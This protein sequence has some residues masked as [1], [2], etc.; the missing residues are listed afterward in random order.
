MTPTKAK[1][2]VSSQRSSSTPTPPHTRIPE[3]KVPVI[4]QPMSAPLG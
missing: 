3:S 1:T 4:P 2:R